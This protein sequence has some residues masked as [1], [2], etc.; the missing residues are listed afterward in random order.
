MADKYPSRL[1]TC[2]YCKKQNINRNKQV[3]GIDWISPS[4]NWYYHTECYKLKLEEDNRKA[5]KSLDAKMEEAEWKESAYY[6]LKNE[7]KI[8]IDYQRLDREWQR[9]VAKGRTPKGIYFTLRYFYDIKSGDRTKSGGSIGIVDY[10]Y[11][12][13]T[14]YWVAREERESGI[15]SKIE[16]LEQEKKQERIIKIDARPRSKKKVYSMV[17]DDD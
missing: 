10:V 14:K 8:V 3:E 11:E 9:L 2:R 13:A 15:L 4:H 17:D 7:M 6:F 12:D 5:A 1:A 16:K